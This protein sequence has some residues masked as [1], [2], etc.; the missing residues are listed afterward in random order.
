[1]SPI[2]GEMGGGATTPRLTPPSDSAPVGGRLKIFSN[3]W[4]ILKSRWSMSVLTNGF[5][6]SLLRAPSIPDGLPECYGSGHDTVVDE[7]VREL[8]LKQAIYEI[9]AQ[10]ATTG[11]TSPILLV[12]KKSGQMRP[13]L[14]LRYINAQIPYRKFQLEGLKQLRQMIRPGDFMTS[15][16][17]MDGYLHV[18]IAKESQNLLQFAWKNR[19]YRFRAL[20]FGLSSA[21][22]IFTKLVRQVVRLCRS[23]GIRLMAYLDDFII[24]GSSYEEC[25]SHT[26]FV[27]DLLKQLG[28]LVNYNKSSLTPSTMLEYL[29]FVID[30]R[31]MQLFVPGPKRKKFRSACQRMLK[32]VSVGRSTKLR[33]FAS[34]AGKLQSLAPAVPFCWLHLQ[35][36]VQTIRSK[37]EEKH[38]GEVQWDDLVEIPV[39]VVEELQWWISFLKGWN[40]SAIIPEATSIDLYSD[41]SNTGYGGFMVVKGKK[42]RQVVQGFW[43]QEEKS[44]STNSRELMAA[45]RVVLAYLKWKRIFGVA[46]RLFTDNLVTYTYINNMGGRFHHLREIAMSILSECERRRVKLVVEHLP[47]VQNVLADRL[48]RAPMDMSE[49]ELSPSLFRYLDALWGPHTVDFFATRYNAKLP[50]FAT[51]GVDDRATYIDGLLHLKK[52]ENGYANPPFSII[53]QVL[54]RISVSSRDLTLIVPA[55]PSQYWWPLLLHLLVEV[56][57]LLPED[58]SLSLS[59]GSQRSPPWRVFACRISGRSAKRKA[60][61]RRLHRLCALGGRNPLI[62]IMNTVGGD[63]PCF[64]ATEAAIDSIL[65]NL[66][67]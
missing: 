14:D 42:A 58:S 63:G 25:R 44:L 17:L 13:C 40:G 32:K 43:S 3:Q 45:Q 8:L 6:I 61:R 53:G 67:F 18:P 65:H 50:R 48:S 35:A 36:V 12:K 1:M 38:S 54:Q 47:G 30:T 9:T 7:H 62:E 5:K 11:F 60:F 56:P 23:R 34:L 64:A 10:Q 15:L 28:W 2:R 51:W 21:P 24:L 33:T 16:D 41:A 29:G 59:S 31:K 19:F 27:M 20:P 57:L 55:W 49:S 66:S 26:C 52:K 37:T 4:R 39:Q 22:W 46:I